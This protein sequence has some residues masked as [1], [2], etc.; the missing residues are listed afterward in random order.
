M[1]QAT[2]HTNKP[3]RRPSPVSGAILGFLLVI[4]LAAFVYAGFLFLQTARSIILNSPQIAN[5]ASSGSAADPEQQGAAQPAQ[6]TTGDQTNSSEVLSAL[7]PLLAPA[8][9]NEEPF[10]VLLLGV[11]Q[12]PGQ[13]NATRTDTM[14]LLH[15]AP[16]TSDV[17]MLSMPRDLWVPIPGFSETR[18]NSA[19]VLGE[20]NNY[21]G[22]GPALAKETVAQLTGQKV[23]YYARI[24]FEGFRRVLEEIGCINITVPFDIDDPTFPDDNYG[25]DPFYIKAG[26]YCMDASIAL[27]YARTRHQDSDFGRMKRQQQVLMAVK[28]KVLSPEELPRLL[29]RLPVLYQAL[30]DSF[31]TDIPASKQIALINMAR[32]LSGGNVRQLVIDQDMVRS[33]VT[34]TGAAVLMPQ[35]DIIRPAIDDFFQPRQPV[36]NEDTAALR[37]Q[38]A[39]ENARIAVLNGT[40]T[41]LLAEQVAQ[42]LRQSGYNVIGYGQADRSD[43]AQT[44]IIDYSGKSLTIDQLRNLLHVAPED[45]RPANEPSTEVDIRLIVGADFQFPPQ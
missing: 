5:A 45:L 24:N 34:P 31:Q 40:D 36:A 35:M 18:I 4:F 25:Y 12:R 14:I 16:K 37:E 9:E 44:Q 3:P 32:N 19:H 11:D 28:N 23:D 7:T 27:K 6:N 42:W 2:P 26:D 21:P 8:W 30:S 43:Y 22:G 20:I 10:N 1:S 41:E 13:G 29:T 15:V 17:G 33:A 38:L 39:T